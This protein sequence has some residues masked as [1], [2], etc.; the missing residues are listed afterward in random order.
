MFKETLPVV[1]NRHKKIS[2]EKK[3]RF[4]PE[5]FVQEVSARPLHPWASS[6]SI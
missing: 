5:H 1:K 6:A 3:E 2:E 4:K